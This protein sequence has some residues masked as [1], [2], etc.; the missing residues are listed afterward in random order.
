MPSCSSCTTASWIGTRLSPRSRTISLRSI[1]SPVRSL[2]VI[3][4]LMMWATTWSF[5]L[6]PYFFGTLCAP[7]FCDTDP[8]SVAR[9]HGRSGVV[10]LVPP[11]AQGFGRGQV[12][13]RAV[14]A[15]GQDRDAEIGQR[16][17]LGAHGVQPTSVLYTGGPHDGLRV[18]ADARAV[19]TQHLRLARVAVAVDER[20][21]HVGV[22]GDQPQG[23]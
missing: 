9:I 19:L 10:A 18:A 23:L 21:P 11:A 20:M 5:S 1:R 17:G 7:H 8:Q 6:T 22:L 3:T 14:G 4:R 2:P 15:D 13:V 16:V 12:I